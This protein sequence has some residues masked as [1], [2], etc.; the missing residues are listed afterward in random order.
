VSKERLS[1]IAEEANGDI[2]A[3]IN[4][5]EFIATTSH[6]ISIIVPLVINQTH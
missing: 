4:T 2:R 6:C 5:L 3:A 1:A